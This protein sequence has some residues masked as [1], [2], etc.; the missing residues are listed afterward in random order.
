ME[1]DQEGLSD[2]LHEDWVT[3]DMPA[4]A[5][6]MSKVLQKRVINDQDPILS[7]R[8]AV[9]EAHDLDVADETTPQPIQKKRRKLFGYTKPSRKSLEIERRLCKA[10]TQGVVQLFNAVN[11]HQQSVKEKVTK[12]GQLE[13]KRFKALTSVD[14]GSFLDMLTSSSATGKSKGSKVNKSPTEVKEDTWE[15]LRDNYMMGS[16]MKDWDQI[17]DNDSATGQFS[18][19]DA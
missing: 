5:D 2:G 17:S 6:V 12:A 19:S 1:D 3:A 10:A 15:V 4:L 9:E 7:K 8:K 13:S 14:K 11:K 16:K 18:D